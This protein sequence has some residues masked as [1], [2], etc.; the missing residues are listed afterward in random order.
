MLKL[1]RKYTQEQ[2]VEAIAE[3]HSVGEVLSKLGLREAGGNYKTIKSHVKTLGL[4]VSHF[5]SLHSRQGWRK[6]STVPTTPRKP[7][8]EILVENSTCTNTHKL[9]GRL[10][11]SGLKE[12][13]CEMCGGV[14]WLG[15]PIPLELHHDNGVRDDFRIENLKLYCPNCHALTS[16][17]RGKGKLG[18]RFAS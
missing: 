17:Y 2:L 6:G 8:V 18:Y 12:R 11:E 4:D 13:K 9:K 16:N 1:I 3:S 15:N 10:L 5:G 14:E 7:L